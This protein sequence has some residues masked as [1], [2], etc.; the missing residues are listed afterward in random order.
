MKKNIASA[1]SLGLLS[2]AACHKDKASLALPALD[3][4]GISKDININLTY[5]DTQ[6]SAK[7]DQWEVIISEPAGK[8]LLDT[9]SPVNTALSAHLHTASYVVNATYVFRGTT[10]NTYS[11]TTY[12]NVDPRSWTAMPAPY[13]SLI[14][15][16]T[17][18]PSER[19]TYYTHPP[20]LSNFEGTDFNDI[21]VSDYTWA[22]GLAGNPDYQPTDPTYQPGGLLTVYNWA[23]GG[24]PVYT[25]FPQPGFYNFHT[26]PATGND[27][28]NLTHMDTTIKVNYR[29]PASYSIFFNTLL[30]YADTTNLNR[31]MTLFINEY[32]GG[33]PYPADLEYPPT[34]VQAYDLD[35]EASNSATGEFIAYLNYDT[36]VPSSVNWLTSADYTLNA[37]LQ[38]SFNIHFNGVKPT[39]YDMKWRSGKIEFEMY[40]APDDAT[41]HPYTWFTHLGSKLLNGQSIPSLSPLNLYFVEATGLPSDFNGYLNAFATTAT[42]ITPPLGTGVIAYSKSW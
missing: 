3:S 19:I 23:H 14:L 9:I 39:F 15:G 6:D 16:D 29:V 38:D 13:L 18:S 28:V 40:S 2:L 10:Y 24:N 36:R 30:G 1:L 31:S 42:P 41:L 7:N 17:I 8:V 27:T 32:I 21:I 35:L 25:L 4:A 22:L 34:G 5:R 33:N 11:V 37:N 20:Y 26:P 12:R